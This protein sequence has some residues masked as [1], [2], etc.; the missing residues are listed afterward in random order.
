MATRRGPRRKSE[1]SARREIL[2]A[3]QRLFPRR[4]LSEIS[5][6]AIA[7]EAQVNPALVLYYF[8]NKEELIIEALGTSLRPVMEDV[9]RDESLHPGVGRQAVLGFLRFWDT[10]ERRQTYAS[11]VLSTPT[12]G[13]LSQALRGTIV[14]QL[15]GQLSGLVPRDELRTRAALYTSQIVGL[16]VSR[17]VLRLEP[18]AS[19][20]PELLANS[21]GPVLDRY[22]ME[23]LPTM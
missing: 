9:F 7:Q 6:R 10:P 22:L 15:E 3:A 21:V 8:E 14:S 18:I 2:R 13:R 4:S 19:M 16:G 1:G 23:P 12:E 11:M 20:S 5:L 17:Y